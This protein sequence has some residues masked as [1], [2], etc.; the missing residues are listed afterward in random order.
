[1]YTRMNNFLI[2]CVDTGN[3]TAWAVIADVYDIKKIQF[4][5]LPTFK[6]NFFHENN[7]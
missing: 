1:M 2:S 3:A 5:F 6:C 7:I 4:T